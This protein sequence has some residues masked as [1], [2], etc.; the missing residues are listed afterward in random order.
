MKRKL[1]VPWTARLGLSRLF[2]WHGR[3]DRTNVSDPKDLK[4]DDLDHLGALHATSI[5]TKKR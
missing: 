5:H 4:E 2:Q 3:G 1:A